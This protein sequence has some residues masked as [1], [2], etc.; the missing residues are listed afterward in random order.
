MLVSH[1]SFLELVV[2]LPRH[3]TAQ[4]GIFVALPSPPLPHHRPHPFLLPMTSPLL[5]W[6]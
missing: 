1:S 4:G 6:S 5:S 3:L 2:S